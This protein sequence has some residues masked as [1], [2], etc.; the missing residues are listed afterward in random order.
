MEQFAALAQRL[1]PTAA[2]SARAKAA[3]T[4][5]AFRAPVARTRRARDR[6]ICGETSPDF[7]VQRA[8][9]PKADHAQ[10]RR[11]QRRMLTAASLARRSDLT[12]IVL[13]KP[14]PDEQP[15]GLPRAGHQHLDRARAAPTSPP[16]PAR[17][18]WITRSPGRSPRARISTA[19]SS[20]RPSSISARPDRLKVITAFAKRADA[21]RA[22]QED[23]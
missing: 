4:L 19:P 22:D 9:S 13:A 23:A 16:S 17:R 21:R 3:A 20:R 1:F 5:G 7:L 11:G 14:V 12:N 15:Q 6:A 8:D 18:R 2:P 10:D